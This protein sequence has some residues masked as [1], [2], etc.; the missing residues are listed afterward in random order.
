MRGRVDLLRRLQ[1]EDVPEALVLEAAQRAP[2]LLRLL[3][4]DV[5]PELPVGAAGV[6]LVADALGQRE[7]DRDRQAVE[8]AR[9]R[10]QRLAR[11]GLHVGRVDDRELARGRGAC[12]R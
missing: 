5:R 10:H 12:A 6:A 7:H 11:L 4:H 2:H 8:L 3:A 1:D 9:E